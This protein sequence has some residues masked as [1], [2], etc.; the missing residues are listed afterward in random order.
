MLIGTGIS[1]H[2]IL[3]SSR[4]GQSCVMKTQELGLRNFSNVLRCFNSE[5]SKESLLILPREG[6]IHYNVFENLK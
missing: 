3:L 5:M 4:P 6:V 2:C 1:R